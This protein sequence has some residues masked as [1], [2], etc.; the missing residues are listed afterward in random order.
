MYASWTNKQLTLQKIIFCAEIVICGIPFA[1]RKAAI[2]VS[3]FKNIE[4]HPFVLHL[5]LS[6]SHTLCGPHK[7]W[8]LWCNGK[9][10]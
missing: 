2:H 1:Y 4:R 7:S 8:T 9:A 3:A 6:M 10:L 5:T